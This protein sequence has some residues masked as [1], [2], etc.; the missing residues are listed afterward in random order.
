MQLKAETRKARIVG[1]KK[2][3]GKERMKREILQEE[4]VD[5]LAYCFALPG[6]IV[7]EKVERNNDEEIVEEWNYREGDDLIMDLFS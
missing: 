4:V 5:G 3:D 1:E 7:E 2:E 6:E